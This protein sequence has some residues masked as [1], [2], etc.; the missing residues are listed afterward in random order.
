MALQ[1]PPQADLFI[2]LL[3]SLPA[4]HTL[5]RL[6]IGFTADTLLLYQRRSY[7]MIFSVS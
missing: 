3:T 7:D 2:Y 6:Y 5:L 4:S 1:H